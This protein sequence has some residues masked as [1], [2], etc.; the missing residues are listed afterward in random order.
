MRIALC[1][2]G[3]L[4]YETLLHL[5]KKPI[6]I[7]CIF[8]DKASKPISD[9]A[10]RNETPLFLGNP[11]KGRASSFIEQHAVDHLFSVN[12]LFIIEEDMIE[13][14]GVYAINIHGSLLP[15]YR[16]RTP[17]V[18]AIINNEYKTGI[19]AHLIDVDCDTGP[20]VDQVEIPIE[21]QD[22]GGK[23]LDKFKMQYPILIDRIL[24]SLNNSDL[25]LTPQDTSRATYFGRRTPADGE[26]DWNWH[27][28][29]IRNWV[30]AQADPYPGA[31]T[32]YG[33]A[34]VIVDEIAYD[35]HGFHQETPNG[36]ILTTNPIR[37]KTPNGAVRL[38][39]LREAP[40]EIKINHKFGSYEDS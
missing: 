30:R 4:G 13:W 14:S 3:Q 38:V 9:W 40:E 5:S 22:T 11:R 34:K 23:L 27:K 24:E 17:H 1:L 39:S 19:T 16:G 21:S 35:D 37:V 7:V 25:K 31:F 8:T 29:R 18:W 6:D 15:K 2:S 26:I 36:T 33:S 10:K 12:Y 32:W 28:E 20:I